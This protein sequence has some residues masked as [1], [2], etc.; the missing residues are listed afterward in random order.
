MIQP[1]QLMPNS[2][3]YRFLPE[4][5]EMAH[6]I[7][8]H[9]W[10]ETLGPIDT[11]SQALKTS[12]GIMLTSKVAMLLFW[13]EDSICFYNDAYRQLRNSQNS[14]PEALGKFAHDVWPEAWHIIGPI[15]S[16]VLEGEVGNLGEDR[17][18]YI[19]H[20]DK[21]ENANYSCSYS[22]VLNGKDQVAGVLVSCV[23][24]NLQDK[25]LRLSDLVT[26]QK[27]YDAAILESEEL[28]RNLADQAPMLIWMVDVNAKI[29]YANKE[30]LNIVGVS[31][32]SEVTVEGGW[33]NVT[34]PD[35]IASVFGSFMD[36]LLKQKPY[37]VEARLKSEAEYQWF[38]F[39]GVPCYTSSGEFNGFIGTAV[40]ID[41]QKMLTKELEIRVKE[42]TIQLDTA[43]LALQESNENLLQ[44][45]HVA[46]HDLKE[47][48]RKIKM[49][50]Y[51]LEDEL[52]DYLT[53][54]G[55]EFLNKI[56]YSTERMSSMID[57]V[58]QYSSLNASNEKIEKIDLNLIID[59]I[60]TDLELIIQQK[61]ARIKCNQLPTI[62]GAN[63]LIYQLFYNLINNSLKF[64]RHGVP[65]E[66]EISNRVIH[67]KGNSY[68]LVELKDNGIG[69][70]QSYADRIFDTFYRLNS[71]DKYEGTGLGLSLCK[72][73]VK[74]HNGTISAKS[75]VDCGSIFTIEL[76]LKQEASFI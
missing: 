31:H 68:V 74:R 43:N 16:Q 61:V 24:D 11:W 50:S 71:K 22:P 21:I 60:E 14:H 58:L 20:N 46:S 27:T 13:G 10:S 1:H 44:F 9:T 6:L 76:P 2:S 8:E 18:V 30:L 33:Q 48:L 23:A 28:F 51:R 67:T 59:S 40:N 47:P 52:K 56:Q 12:L 34:H 54:I 41:E 36:A 37:V 25:N 4:R 17:F 38:V 63:V 70:E 64:T 73:I 5:S 15:I 53:D 35:D 19:P 62:E 7:Y 45:A 66:I 72:K 75:G 32:Y 42:R 39:K 69:F 29:T 55:R 49:L 57:G 3:M 26:T 65:P